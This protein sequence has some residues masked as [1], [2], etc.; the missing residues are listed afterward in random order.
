MPDYAMNPSE[1]RVVEMKRGHLLRRLDEKVTVNEVVRPSSE[2]H[3]KPKRRGK[4]HRKN[5]ARKTD[6]L[7]YMNGDVICLRE[8]TGRFYDVEL[9][10]A[11][12]IPRLFD[13][14]NPLLKNPW[15]STEHLR[16]FIEFVSC[17]NDLDVY[18]FLL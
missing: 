7:A 16:E 3:K 5:Q 11:A 8:P 2:K 17:H 4:K 15:I 9:A 10:R 1:G 14:V 18:E 12:T 6:A 13:W